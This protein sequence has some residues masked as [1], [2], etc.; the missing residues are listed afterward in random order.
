[1]QNK[2]S[3]DKIQGQ[4][5]RNEMKKIMAG[6]ASAGSTCNCNSKDDCKDNMDCLNSCGGKVGDTFVGI[7]G[8]QTA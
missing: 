3:L 1:M 7:C 8:C 5:S 2:I 6:D 4:L